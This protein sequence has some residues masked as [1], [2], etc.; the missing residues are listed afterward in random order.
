MRRFSVLVRAVPSRALTQKEC[1]TDH[2]ATRN[3]TL[4]L[5][6]ELIRRLK[7]I[8]QQDISIS[9]LLTATLAQLADQEEGYA[10]AR[11]G[12]LADLARGY[13]LGTQG[14]IAWIRKA[15]HER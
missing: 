12:M 11:D 7:V 15:L 3:V 5:P 14:R 8:A 6:E 10:E 9:A 13:D 2:V 1:Q 4:S